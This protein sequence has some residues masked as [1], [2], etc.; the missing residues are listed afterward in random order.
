V[1]GG[2]PRGISDGHSWASTT[3][4][5]GGGLLNDTI[6]TQNQSGVMSV[7]PTH[8]LNA[9]ILGEEQPPTHP[10]SFS[11]HICFSNITDRAAAALWTRKQEWIWE[12]AASS[13]SCRV[14]AARYPNVT[15]PGWVAVGTVG[16]GQ[17][18]CNGVV[19]LGSWQDSGHLM[20]VCLKH[21][22]RQTSRI[23]PRSPSGN[24]PTPTSRRC[25]G[26]ILATE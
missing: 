15:E 6:K 18:C 2:T 10:F 1:A 25:S 20:N 21:C 14:P 3:Q 22:T 16:K 12:P 24:A 8:N 23:F 7:I 9:H 5:A 19:R 17:A 13:R 26:L 4:V 11:A